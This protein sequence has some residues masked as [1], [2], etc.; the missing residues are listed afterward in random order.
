MYGM[1]CQSDIKKHIEKHEILTMITAAL[2][3]DLDHPGYNNTYQVG[4]SRQD[5]LW[6]LHA[7]IIHCIIDDQSAVT[8]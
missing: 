1:I 6:K 3:H 5:Y 2:C 8:R 7:L 4:I